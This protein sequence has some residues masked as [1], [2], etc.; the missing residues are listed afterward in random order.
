MDRVDVKHCS[1]PDLGASCVTDLAQL[2]SPEGR[3]LV[4]IAQSIR[5]QL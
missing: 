3:H 4:N 1:E 2:A 5:G